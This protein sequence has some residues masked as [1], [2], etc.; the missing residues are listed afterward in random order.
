LPGGRAQPGID[1]PSF[2]RSEYADESR[3]VERNHVCN[4]FSD[5]IDTE[6]VVLSVVG[7]SGARRVLEIGCGTGAFAA[8]LRSSLDVDVTA[9][10]ISPRMVEL[11]LRQ[12]VKAHVA[13]A[14]AL[15]FAMES[16]DCVV[17]NWMLYHVE[18]I[19]QCL[20]ECA[21]VL[22]KQGRLVTASF[23]RSHLREVW[24]LPGAPALWPNKFH[25]GAALPFL[26]AHFAET[27]LHELKA[28]VRFPTVA[29]VRSC[30]DAWVTSDSTA[31]VAV[32]AEPYHARCHHFVAIADGPLK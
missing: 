12:G 11:A 20:R 2:V 24:A 18:S 10:D 32:P 16:F 17:A 30:I 6:D 13:D 7:E 8:R 22:T 21:R 14:Q 1:D 31:S 27:R 26:R 23:G 3:L 29:S 9:I 4:A 19:P 15:P 25:E 28:V 5:G